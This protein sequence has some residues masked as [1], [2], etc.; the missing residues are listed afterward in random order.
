MNAKEIVA[1]AHAP[2]GFDWDTIQAILGGL[3]P[4]HP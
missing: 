1:P 2:D 4:G 3:N